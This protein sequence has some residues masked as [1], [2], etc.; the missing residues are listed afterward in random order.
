[1]DNEIK[2]YPT[3]KIK[4]DNLFKTILTKDEKTKTN[5]FTKI[6]NITEQYLAKIDKIKQKKLYTII[7]Y[8]D[9]GNTYSII[10]NI[11]NN[12]TNGKIIGSDLLEKELTTF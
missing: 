3:Y 5:Y 2:N 1:V 10:Q 8:L 7:S 4:V 9:C 12:I 11:N 6:E